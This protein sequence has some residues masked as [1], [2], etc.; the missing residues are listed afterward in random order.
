MLG[1]HADLELFAGSGGYPGEGEF[2]QAFRNDSLDTVGVGK[3]QEDFPSESP[4]Y[5]RRNFGGGGL[6]GSTLAEKSPLFCEGQCG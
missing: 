1:A 2:F 3:V 4:L 5:E 6:R